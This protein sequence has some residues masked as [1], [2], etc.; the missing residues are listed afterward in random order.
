[1]A[2]LDR[3]LFLG[4]RLKRLRYDLSLTQT[5]MAADLGVSASYLNHLERNQRPV[6]DPGQL[7]LA[8]TCH[9]DLRRLTHES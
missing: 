7:K 1:M 4:G 9:R 3:K 8:A 6:T 5:Q 2:D